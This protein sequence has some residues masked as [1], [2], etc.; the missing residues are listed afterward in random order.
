MIFGV[1]VCSFAGP[2]IAIVRA[3]AT[4]T[5][6]LNVSVAPDAAAGPRLLQV[7]TP[8]GVAFLSGALTVTSE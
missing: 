1:V 2:G 8:A 7:T 4:R 3:R 5:I 6:L